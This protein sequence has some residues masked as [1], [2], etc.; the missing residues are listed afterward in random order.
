MLAPAD[1]IVLQAERTAGYGNLLT[2]S[3]G[4]GLVTRY[5]HLQAF[6]ARPGSR[7]RRGDVIGYVGSTGR[8]TASHLHYEILSGGRQVDPMSYVVEDVSSW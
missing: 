4:D 3:H 1:G 8:S 7:V 5:G 6:K 2:L